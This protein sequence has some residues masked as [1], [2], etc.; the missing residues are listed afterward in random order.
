VCPLGLIEP[1]CSGERDRFPTRRCL[2]PQVDGCLVV[3]GLLGVA[4]RSQ[5][6]RSRS[7]VLTWR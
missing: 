5:G 7:S 4:G 3:S 2:P 1:W 6:N